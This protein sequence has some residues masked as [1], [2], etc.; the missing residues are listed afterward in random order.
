M[1]HFPGFTQKDFDVFTISGLEERMEALKSN[2]SP[3]LEFAAQELAPYLTSITGDEMFVHV[4]KH[5]RRTTNPPNDTWAALA[6]SKKGYKKLPHFQIGLWE[7]HVF[8]WF[9]VIYESPIK[10]DFAKVLKQNLKQVRDY[11]P[12]DYVWSK[13][14]TKPEAIPNK[15][16]SDEEFEGLVDRLQN[17]K[18]AELLCGVHIDRHD[19][20]LQDHDAFIEKCEEIFHK[21]EY[22]YRLTKEIE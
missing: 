19:V 13:D 3:K 5:A 12:A 7:S 1:N 6:N 15:D 21:L 17:V 10:Q 8:I 16:L 18:K 4:A 9:A 22:L 11:I 20:V 14:H 2:V